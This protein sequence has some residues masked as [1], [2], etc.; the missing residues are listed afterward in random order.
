MYIR[1]VQIENIRSIKELQWKVPDDQLA[2]W[3]VI[4]GDNGAGKTTVLRSIALALIGPS[5]VEALRQ[6]WNEWLRSSEKSG[7][8]KFRFITW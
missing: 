2:G 8:I 4:I 7:S 5:E 3:H 6:N 1:S